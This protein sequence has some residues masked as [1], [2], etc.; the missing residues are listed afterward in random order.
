[1]DRATVNHRIQASKIPNWIGTDQIRSF[2]IQAGRL[3]LRADIETRG[4]TWKFEADLERVL[5]E[6]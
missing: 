6:K 4:E 2:E 3:K 1:M 5:S